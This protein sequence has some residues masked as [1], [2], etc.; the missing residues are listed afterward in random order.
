MRR[1]LFIAFLFPPIVNSGT[2][3]S[4]SFANRLPEFGWQPLV[5]ACEPDASEAGSGA[6]LAEVRE[7]TSVAR[8]PLASRSQ[9]DA[10]SAL[11]P[12]PMASTSG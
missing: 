5:L 10:V 8:V 2:R 1:V 12:Q 9:A 7:G 6:L 3:R 4:L 11:G